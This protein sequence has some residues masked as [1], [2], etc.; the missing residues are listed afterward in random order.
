MI[1]NFLAPNVYYHQRRNMLRFQ[2]LYESY[3][4]EIYRFALSLSGEPAEAEDI[5]SETFI[6]AWVNKNAIRTETL[7]A[8]LMTIARNTFLERRRKSRRE[9]AL[10]ETL[11]DPAAGPDESAESRIG[12]MRVEKLLRTLPEIDRAAFVLRVRHGLPYEEIARV[13]EITL[14]SAKVKVHRV[15]KRLL[16]VCVER[17]VC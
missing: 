9:V 14:A 5:T 12:L 15:R 4:R 8:Y 11:P 13:L 16:A 10:E 17:K 6:R 1:C 7:K 2:E 3:A